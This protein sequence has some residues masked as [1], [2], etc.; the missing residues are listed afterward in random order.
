MNTVIEKIVEGLRK[1]HY[2]ENVILFG[3]RAGSNYKE[4]SDYDLCIVIDDGFDQNEVYCL[5][6]KLMIDYEVIIH[7]HIF[8]HSVF[9]N[10]MKISIY[11]DNI[12]IKGKL[13]YKR[14]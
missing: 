6:S 8:E 1:Y 2:V 12:I 3:S 9:L 13:L 14:K 7:P 4:S 10:K 11:L 5:L